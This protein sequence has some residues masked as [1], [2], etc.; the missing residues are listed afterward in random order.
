M[1]P[2]RTLSRW[3]ASLACLALIFVTVLQFL[4]VVGRYFFNS[5]LTFAVELVQ[6][7]MGVLVLCGLAITTMERGHIAV[8]LI[9]TL[10]SGRIR[11]VLAAIAAICG[12]VFISL[13]AWR[14]TNRGMNFFSDGLVTDILSV[15]V[16]PVVLL[17][18]AATACAALV[19]FVGIFSSRPADPAPIEPVE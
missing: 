1:T 8:D 13:M 14:L 9:D 2:L 17:M 4:D 6:L 11:K 19:A 10:V 5:P 7:G 16:W 3:L 12:F 18:A 15:P